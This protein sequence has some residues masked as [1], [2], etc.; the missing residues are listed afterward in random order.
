MGAVTYYL[1]EHPSIVG[2]RW[3]SA[4]PWGSTWSSL[5]AALSVYLLI[6]LSLSATLSL[7][8]RRR[9]VPLGPVPLLHSL[10]MFLSSAAILAGTAASARLEIRD[11]SWFWRR[12]KTPFQWLLCFPL[13]TRPSGRLFFWSYLFYLSRYLHLLK[14]F[15][16]ILRRRRLT[17]S[18]LL[19]RSMEICTCFLWL[20]FSQSF[21]IL[22]ILSSTLAGVVVNGYRLW[23]SVGL[24]GGC[25]PV[26]LGCRIVLYACNL[27]CSVGVLM[28]HFKKGG[29]NGIGAWVFTSVLNGVLTLLFLNFCVRRHLKRRR[30][31]RRGLGFDDDD[32][33]VSVGRSTAATSESDS[34]KDL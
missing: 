29:C 11:T 14:T 27:V 23:V 10:L 22:A 16:S 30:S 21:Q 8:R 32:C 25:V 28:L 33:S 3:G 5:A 2:F 19:Y 9:P 12:H 6:S 1:T 26:V 15:I 20:E 13:G 24:P 4:L 34:K 31:G 17:L 7:L 18:K